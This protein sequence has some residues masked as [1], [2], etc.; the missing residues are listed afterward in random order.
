[1]QIIKLSVWWGTCQKQ[2]NMGVSQPCNF[3]KCCI[4]DSLL[5]WD[6]YGTHLT[7]EQVWHVKLKPVCSRMYYVKSVFW[8]K[9]VILKYHTFCLHALTIQENIFSLTK[10]ITT[11]W[12]DFRS[13]LMILISKKKYNS[14][15]P[16]SIWWIV[17]CVLSELWIKETPVDVVMTL[18][19][20]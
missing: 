1:M 5:Y 8:Y 11:F 16:Y 15:Y 4:S 10:L 14:K 19:I 7:Y 18:N 6:I 20:I 3:W 9:L 17:P 12:V 2:S 13:F